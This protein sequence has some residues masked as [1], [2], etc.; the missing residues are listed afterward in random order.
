MV[1]LLTEVK[2][3]RPHQRL[4]QRIAQLRRARRLTQPELAELANVSVGYIGHIEVGKR[5]PTPEVLRA[6]ARAL[7]ADFNELAM[8]AG[9]ADTA[10][11]GEGWVPVD[12][13]AQKAPIVRKVAALP[14]EFLE[15]VYRLFSIASL[16]PTDRSTEQKGESG[17]EQ[18]DADGDPPVGPEDGSGS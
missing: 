12:V 18:Q 7:D 5:R 17:R 13:P 3:S 14:Q 4:A 10:P 1:A 16:R 6:I 8:L 11:T 2:R 15:E 9:Y